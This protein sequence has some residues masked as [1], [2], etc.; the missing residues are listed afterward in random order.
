MKVTD[1]LPVRQDDRQISP[2]AMQDAENQPMP[3]VRVGFIRYY[4]RPGLE[5]TLAKDEAS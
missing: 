4:G 5:V 3:A 1:Q 2:F